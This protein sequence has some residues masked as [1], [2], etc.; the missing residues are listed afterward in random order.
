MPIEGVIR[1]V[2]DGIEFT[3]ESWRELIQRRSEFRRPP[4]QQGRNP[5]TGGATVF[6]PSPDAADV[7]LEGRPVGEVYW[8]MSEEPLVNVSVEPSAMP[9]VLE[10]AKELG[11]EFRPESP[12][13]GQ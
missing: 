5:F 1:P 2:G 8:S 11:G 13:T 3:R 12:G 10:W 4:P 6:H 7:V 9:L